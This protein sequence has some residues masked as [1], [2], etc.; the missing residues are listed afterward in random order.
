MTLDIGRGS[1]QKRETLMNEMR[2]A[3]ADQPY[4]WITM[5]LSV[6]CAIH[7]LL[8]PA[9]LLAIPLVGLSLA[10]PT[11]EVWSTVLTLSLS[12]Y[13]LRSGFRQHANYRPLV[14]AAAGGVLLS[15][16]VI[17][18]GSEGHKHDEW[19]STLIGVSLLLASHFLNLRV[20]KHKNS[21]LRFIASKN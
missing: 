2:Q 11:F 5:L 9:L 8:H 14:L 6:G 21:K 18:L 19:I 12:A 17:H 15:W 20:L 16:N 1:A 4:D 13:A 10:S 7:C 3:I